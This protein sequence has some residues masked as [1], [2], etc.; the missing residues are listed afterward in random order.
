M[1]LQRLKEGLKKK[2][3]LLSQS[4]DD[5]KVEK[6]ARRG[7]QQEVKEAKELLPPCKVMKVSF[8]CR[9]QIMALLTRGYMNE[10]RYDNA[11]AYVAV[12]LDLRPES[13]F[14]RTPVSGCRECGKR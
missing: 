12:L 5:L 14:V 6:T 3:N 8:P 2:E 7:L 9:L 10:H 1:D 4:L 13:F 11:S